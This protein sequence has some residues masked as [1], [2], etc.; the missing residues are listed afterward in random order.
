[1]GSF[2]K[3]NVNEV[4]DLNLPNRVSVL[5]ED[6]GEAA[7]PPHDVYNVI[8]CAQSGSQQVPTR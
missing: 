2:E 1:M 4:M 6:I 5:L 3:L 7:M 8:M